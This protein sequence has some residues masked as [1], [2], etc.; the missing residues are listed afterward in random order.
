MRDFLGELKRRNVYKVTAAYLVAAFVVLQLA[1]LAAGAFAL[2]GWFEP[3]VWVLCGLGFPLAIVLAW[4]FDLTPEGVRRTPEV[5]TEREDGTR[6]S[7]SR[8]PDAP[9]AGKRSIAV[10]PFVALGPEDTGTLTEG[11]HDE[12]LGRLSNVSGLKVISRTSLQQYRDTDK[13]TVRIA[14]ELG[15]KWVVE[16]G[17]Q[18]VGEQI[19]VNAQ[20]IDPGT[21]TH[22]WAKSYRRDLTAK[23]LFE[24]QSDI[25]KRIVRSLEAELTPEEEARVERMPTDNLDAYRLYVRGRQ[26]LA[27][28]SFDTRIGETLR[29]AAK[30]FRGA[31]REDPDFALAWAGLADV[32]LAYRRMITWVK[33]AP[34]PAEQ[35]RI[36]GLD[37]DLSDLPEPGEAARR[38]LDRDPDLAEARASMGSIHLQKLEAPAAARELH[39]A[40][41]LK[42]SYWEAHHWLGELYLKIGRPEKALDHVTLAVELNPRHAQARHWLYDTFLVNGRGEASL[43]EARRQQRMG[44]EEESAVGGE[45]RAL[46]FLGRLEEARAVAE[47][48]ISNLGVEMAWGAWFRAYLVLILASQG[49]TLRARAHLEELEDATAD[50]NMLA[51]AYA[52]LG[53]TD[54]AF[55]AFEALEREDWG[56]IDTAAGLRYPSFFGLSVLQDDPRYEEW[57]CRVNRYWGL[58]PDGRLPGESWAAGSAHQ[59]EVV[60]G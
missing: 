9:R 33:L 48:E 12:L 54:K 55:E 38:A 43:R 52:G 4:A 51:W 26:R 11:M 17:V 16:G 13:T 5:G 59:E 1:E 28:R 60:R 57:I 30:D 40:I 41:A 35:R 14:R 39:R 53:K 21:D 2:P 24:L 42:P 44:L 23:N 46:R 34:D 36:T 45:V 15:V 29:D 47:E 50:P 7:E 6:E 37:S 58:D 32:A 49:E 31:I 20:L 22:A 18:Q 25:T 27:E 3:M 19:R 10:L 8:F 56:R